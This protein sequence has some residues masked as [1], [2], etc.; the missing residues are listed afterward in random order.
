VPYHEVI[1]IDE[2]V[3]VG[4]APADIYGFY[5]IPPDP[6]S[7]AEVVRGKAEGKVPK[8]LR[9]RMYWRVEYVNP[10]PLTTAEGGI[11][12]IDCDGG[13][14]LIADVHVSW[15]KPVHKGEVDVTEHFTRCGAHPFGINAVKVSMGPAGWPFPIPETKFKVKV[16]AKVSWGW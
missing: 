2:E 15:Q 16:V 14:P 4:T 11:W 9:V 1:V 10:T 7:M 5:V 12:I 6:D 13:E 8:I 3:T